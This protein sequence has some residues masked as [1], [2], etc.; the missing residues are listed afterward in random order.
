MFL[1]EINKMNKI[2]KILAKILIIS[3]LT[4]NNVSALKFE[5]TQDNISYILDDKTQTAMVN[6]V[7]TNSDGVAN[8]NIPPFVEFDKDLYKVL[9]LLRG[10][11]DPFVF[12]KINKVNIPYTI[13]KDGNNKNVLYNLLSSPNITPIDKFIVKDYFDNYFDKNLSQR[14]KNSPLKRAVTKYLFLSGS[15]INAF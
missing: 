5:I 7:Y 14:Q 3:G 2:F 6:K 9:G 12:F 4:F 8:L 11:I 13:I 10:C 1:S 15:Q